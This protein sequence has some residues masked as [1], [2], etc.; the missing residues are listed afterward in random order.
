MSPLAFGL[1]GLI[2]AYRYTLSPLIG[3]ACRFCPT[4]SEYA[5]EAVERHGGLRGGWLALRRF[6]RCNPWGGAGYDPVPEPPKP[7][8][9]G[10]RRAA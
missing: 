3:Q 8:R 5:L 6:A 4:C 7:S 2:V 9:G 1:R 10:D